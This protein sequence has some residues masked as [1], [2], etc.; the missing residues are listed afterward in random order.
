[1][2]AEEEQQLDEASLDDAVRAYFRDIS[3]VRLLTAAE[4]V[5]L[6]QQIEAG[7][8]AA[9]RRMIESNLRL[10][11]SVAKKYGNLGLMRAVEKF[12]YR[13]GFKFSTYATWWIRQA[14]QRAVAD[15]SRTIRIPT[16]NADTI[17]KLV[18]VA[19]R[20]RSELGRRPTNAE[21]GLEMGLESEK[22]AWLLEIAREP[23]SLETP[24]G[25]GDTELG[26]LI[27]D[28]SVES[29]LAAAARSMMK[30][31]VQ[32]VLETLTARERRVLQLRFGL[33]D[34]EQRTLE[35]VARRLGLGRETV[36]QLERTAMARL[37][38]AGRA[39]RLKAHMDGS[40]A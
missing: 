32:A 30:D 35:E 25:D 29:P 2:K 1:M 17:N 27:E 16:H 31:E 21:I 5:E 10:V 11:V 26:E 34:G 38:E 3:R 12:D 23:V 6:A 13:R 28:T 19:D 40:A 4:E 33:L 24:I 8:E 18:R 7:S 37:R 20:L 39:E 22:V 36:R 9:R 15:R 14:C